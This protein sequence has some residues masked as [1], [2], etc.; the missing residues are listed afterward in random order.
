MRQAWGKANVDEREARRRFAAAS[1]ASLATVRAD[2]RPHVV[3]VVF[4]VEHDL[5]F[6]LVDSKPKTGRMLQRVRNLQVNPRGS[7]LVDHYEA[8]W[9]RLWW[10]RADGL[11]VIADAGRDQMRAVR[12]LRA[13]YRQY[14]P[15]SDFGAAIVIR[16]ERWVHWSSRT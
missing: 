7:L 13:K 1:V 12:N 15:E 14:S 9:E 11:A 4:A 3:P 16:V 8:D 2:G 10:V 5:I 6:T